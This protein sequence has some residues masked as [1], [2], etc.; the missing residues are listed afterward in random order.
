[1]NQ[2]KKDRVNIAVAKD[3]AERLAAVAE[4]LGMTQYALANQILATGLELVQQGFKVQQIREIAEFYKVMVELE[5]VPVPGRLLDKMVADMY[6]ENP[7]VVEKAWCE[8]G[9][10]LASYIKAVYGGLDSALSLVP[11]FSKVIPAKRFD[12]KASGDELVVDAVGVGY[13][14]ESV[15]ATA[16]G[17]RCFLEDLGYEV[18]EVI[19]AP[20]IL[21][22]R[23]VKK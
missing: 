12:V 20:G 18:K 11:Y 2:Q 8:A 14:V 5:V 17:A 3:V 1:V 4:S 13:G 16:A 7:E 19:T 22:V 23:A 15:K 21:R 10:M 9:K 6:K